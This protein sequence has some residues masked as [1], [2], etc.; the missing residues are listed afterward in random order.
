MIKLEGMPYEDFDGEWYHLHLKKAKII[1]F[2]K[3]EFPDYLKWGMKD[4]EISL[5]GFILQFEDK[6]IRITI[7]E[8]E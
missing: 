4:D 6:R 5:E 2:G 7:E 3:G 1:E 8:I